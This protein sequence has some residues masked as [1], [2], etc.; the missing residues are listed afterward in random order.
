MSVGFYAGTFD[1]FTNGHLLVT[2]KAAKL[3]DKIIIGM[4]INEKKGPRQYDINLMKKAIEETLKEEGLSN[5]EV[6]TFTGLTVLE[7][8]TYDTTYLIRGIRTQTDYQ[9]EEDLAIKNEKLAN[10][11]TLYIRSGNIGYISS[12]FIKGLIAENWDVSEYVPKPV[13]DLIM[14][15]NLK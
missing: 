6:T 4:G 9:E 8:M 5:V 12:S 7:A 10:I 11:D 1:I 3:F 14:R 2:K 15:E 13:Y